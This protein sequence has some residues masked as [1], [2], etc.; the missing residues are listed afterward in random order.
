MKTLKF[1]L[2]SIAVLLMVV[3]SCSRVPLTGRKQLNIIPG[4]QMMAMSFQ[5]YSQFLSENKLSSD[6]EATAMVK[7][8]GQKIQHAVERYFAE[9]DLSARLKNYAWEFNLVESPEANAWCMPGGKVVF[10]TGILPITKDETGLAVVMGHEVAH[11]IAE[12]GGER[13][14]QQLMT[15]MGGMALAVAMQDK[16]EQTQALWMAAFGLGSQLGILLPYSR[17]HESEADRLGLIF[18]AMAGYDPNEAIA[19]WERMAKMKGGQAPPEF[20]S[21]HPSDETRI[22]QI[23]KWLPEAMKY[24]NRD[25]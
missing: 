10:Y 19:F 6:A 11:A 21:T 18:M 23:R 8:V 25:R 17:L 14:S 4:Q 7:N 5:Q 16:P 2:A 12:H 9:K 20:L 3:L 24:Y 13:M 15:Q 22:A 1:Y